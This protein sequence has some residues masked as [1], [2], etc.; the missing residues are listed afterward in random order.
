MS[1]THPTTRNIA[2]PYGATSHRQ[3]RAPRT[4]LTIPAIPI[5]TRFLGW[6]LAAIVGGLIA[7]LVAAPSPAQAATVT[8]AASAAS[9]STVCQ[10]TSTHVC[11][12][13]LGG[14]TYRVT[15][16]SHQHRT[17]FARVNKGATAPHLVAGDC[18]TNGAR[19][20]L[21]KVASVFYAVTFTPDLHLARGFQ[22]V[23][24]DC[25]LAEDGSCVNPSF[26]ASK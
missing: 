3:T 23:P 6:L 4:T 22:R 25:V 15:F 5:P 9:A 20:C 12:V 7:A 26:Y 16:D 10:F 2:M 11:S 18:R 21:V 14:D 24:A 8:S 19:T 13:K 17:G 1:T